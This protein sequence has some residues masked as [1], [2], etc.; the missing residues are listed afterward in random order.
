VQVK[1]QRL[2]STAEWLGVLAVVISV[3]FLAL[4]VRQANQIARA[5]ASRELL[6]LFNDFHDTAVSDPATLAILTTLAEPDPE[7]ST[8]EKI[9]ARH[10]A[11]RLFNSFNAVHDAYSE[12]F[13]PDEVYADYTTAAG[14][15]LRNYPGL[16]PHLRALLEAMPRSLTSPVWVPVV[17]SLN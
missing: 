13:V 9:Q 15:Y 16:E 4:Q 1:D 6:S 7:L 5:E 3:A 12:G 2:R 14:R 10:L 8:S 11:M 17:E